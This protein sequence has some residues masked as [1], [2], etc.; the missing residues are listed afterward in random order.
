MKTPAVQTLQSDSSV[1]QNSAPQQQSQYVVVNSNDL[2][3]YAAN[4]GNNQLTVDP[5]TSNSYNSQQVLS[6]QQQ[7]MEQQQTE[8][9]ITPQAAPVYDDDSNEEGSDS[10]S[11]DD[12]GDEQADDGYDSDEDP[13]AEESANDGSQAD[14]YDDDTQSYSPRKQQSLAGDDEKPATDDI[15]DVTGSADWPKNLPGAM[16]DD[17]SWVIGMHR[18]PLWTDSQTGACGTTTP[19][20]KGMADR[21]HGFQMTTNPWT[22]KRRTFDPYAQAEEEGRAN[23]PWDPT[24]DPQVCI[25]C[26]YAYRCVCMRAR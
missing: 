6:R 18:E 25:M 17:T 9:M 10:E 21:G 3:Q 11:Q 24:R 14:A 7:D 12:G 8:A 19:C 26:V 1:K 20:E 23:Y 4:A 22:D 2:P 13:N 16:G 15:A 5:S